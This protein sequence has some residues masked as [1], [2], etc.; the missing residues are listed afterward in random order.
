[1]DTETMT[2]TT[3]SPTL[4]KEKEDTAHEQEG[5]DSLV[6]SCLYGR[7]SHPLSPP[8][9]SEAYTVTKDE[10]LVNIRTTVQAY[11]KLKKTS[12][13]VSIAVSGA[14]GVG[15]SRSDVL[16]TLAD[17]KFPFERLTYILQRHLFTPAQAG[18]QDAI[19]GVRMASKDPSYVTSYERYV[20]THPTC[21]EANRRAS[22]ALA[23]V[24]EK[25]YL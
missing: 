7:D 20:H 5:S 1:M 10:S 2:T 9:F 18:R 15:V 22:L 3:M 17:A 24:D 25:V 11:H 16:E 8:L 19:E 14:L 6:L 4:D 23:M 13:N 12:I 21:P